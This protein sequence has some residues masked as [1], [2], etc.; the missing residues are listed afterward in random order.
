MLARLRISLRVVQG[1]RGQ[2]TGAKDFKDAIGMGPR[3]PKQAQQQQQAQEEVGSVQGWSTRGLTFVFHQKKEEDSDG[4]YVNP[5]T[6][7]VG[8]PRGPEPTR[9]GDWERKGRCYDF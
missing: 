2:A 1:V 3:P 6:G 9:F 8:G 4:P 5:T 7:E